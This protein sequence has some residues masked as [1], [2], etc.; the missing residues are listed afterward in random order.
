M[1]PSTSPPPNGADTITLGAGKDLVRYTAVAQ[2]NT[3]MD[4]ITDF[5]SGTDRLDLSY[6]DATGTFVTDWGF[7][8]NFTSSDQFVGN[9]PTF[10]QAQGAL[11]GGGKVSVVFQ[12]DEQI[13][14]LDA[15]GDGTLD[16]NDFRVRLSGVK[17]HRGGS[18][19]WSPAT[20]S[21]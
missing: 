2:S 18:G 21:P 16:N 5:V 14:W 9:R 17:P 1:T 10:A 8:L 4:T 19:L 7:G 11:T 15:N 13:L 12:Q 20:P 3:K 6:T